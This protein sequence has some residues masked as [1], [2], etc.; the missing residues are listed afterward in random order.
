MVPQYLMLATINS[1]TTSTT[2]IATTNA[3]AMIAAM[4][5]LRLVAFLF[6]SL[7]S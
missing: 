2:I 6:N 7:I 3:A 4:L 5:Q 1:A